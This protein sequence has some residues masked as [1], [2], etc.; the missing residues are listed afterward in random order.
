MTLVTQEP[1]EFQSQNF[2]ST[3]IT[4]YFRDIHT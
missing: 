2:V 4:E 1:Q 3:Y